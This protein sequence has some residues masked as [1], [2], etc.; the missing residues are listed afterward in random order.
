MK[1][2]TIFS[3]FGFPIPME[4]RFK[5][6]KA[7]GFDGVLLWWSDE[8]AD[9]DGDKFHH[10]ELAGRNGLFIENM[11]APIFRN[12]YLWKDCLDGEAIERILHNCIDDCQRFEIPTVV[13]HL[14]YEVNP[15]SFTKTGLDRVKRLVEAAERKNVNLAI[16]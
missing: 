4:E 14:T 1:K 13:V 8:H 5:L 10:P 15:P 16:E 11:H 9:V 12:N 6:I 7:T 3:W 2:L